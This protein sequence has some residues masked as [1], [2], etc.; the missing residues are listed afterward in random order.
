M[1][2]T[3]TTSAGNI[4]Q[5]QPTTR[6]SV[7]IEPDRLSFLMRHRGSHPPLDRQI[8]MHPPSHPS[9][10]QN[11]GPQSIAPPSTHGISN[12]PV[13][14]QSATPRVGLSGAH[15]G[16]SLL[17]M[18]ARPAPPRSCFYDVKRAHPRR[19]TRALRNEPPLR[20]CFRALSHCREGDVNTFEA[21]R[22]DSRSGDGAQRVALPLISADS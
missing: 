6:P 8:G 7:V 22:R 3:P 20:A 21:H 16:G 5:M 15:S 11:A 10:R 1:P 18:L 4:L 14:V 19:A 9:R 13:P 17:V 2:P 12:G